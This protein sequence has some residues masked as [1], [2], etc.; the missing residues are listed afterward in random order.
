MENTKKLTKRD[1]FE[2]IK[3]ICEGRQDLIDFCNHELELLAKKNSKGGTTKT[4]A[5]N[6][7]IAEMLVNELEKIGVP[8]TITDLMNQSETIKNYTYKTKIDGEEKDIRLTN[9]KISAIFKQL[10]DNGTLAKTTEKK[11][12]YFSVA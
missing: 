1:Y 12:S 4:Q 11:K 5:E 7:K 9:Q 2:M 3:G 10:V 8:S 6:V